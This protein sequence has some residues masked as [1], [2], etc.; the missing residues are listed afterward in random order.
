MLAFRMEDSA[1]NNDFFKYFRIRIENY[2]YN[3]TSQT[4]TQNPIFSVEPCTIE[5]YVNMTEE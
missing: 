3:Y 5:H 2:Y 4:T 1:L